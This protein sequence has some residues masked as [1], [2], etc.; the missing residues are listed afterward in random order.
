MKRIL[1]I[2]ST[3]QIGSELTR[4]LRRL[5]GNEQVVA[6][7]IHGAE[8]TGELK[9]GGPSALADVTNG[10]M[11]TDVV[12]KYQI[13]TIFNLAALLSVVAE[14]KPRLAWKIGIDGLFNILEIARQEHCAVFT[15]SSIGSF[16]LETPHDKTPQDTIQRPRTI[17]GISKVTTELLSDYYYY[18]Y[19]VDTRSVRFPGIISYLTLPGGGTT[20]YAVDIFYAAVRG[21]KFVCPLRQGTYMDMMYMPDALHA[22]IS[23]MQADPARLKH[24]NGFNVTAMSFAPEIIYEEIKK[25]RPEFEMEYDVDPMKQ[26]IADSWPDCLD[27]SAAREEWDWQPKYDISSMTKDMLEQLSKRI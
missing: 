27:D 11:L 24:R 25:Y 22:A 20:D 23:L 26:A 16:G 9:D 14:S 5:Y 4:E 17:Y 1:V 7:Y 6:G 8:P 13:D 18:K 15:P 12:K 3:G 2:G 19:G 10:D 21:E